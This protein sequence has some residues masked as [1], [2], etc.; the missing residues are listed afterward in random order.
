MG[1]GW[2]L[3]DLHII[4]NE[5]PKSKILSSFLESLGRNRPA[6]HLFLLGDIFDLWVGSS[7]FFADQYSDVVRS[8]IK[9][10]KRGIEVI[11][12]EGNH[13]VHIK[14]FWSQFGVTVTNQD[15]RFSFNGLQLHLSHGD[16]INPKEV[17]YH[18]YIR[19]VRSSQGFIL[20]NL[21]PGKVWWKIGQYA[22]RKSRR[23]SSKSRPG[24]KE[25]LEKDFIEF[26]KIQHQNAPFDLLIAGHIHCPIDLEFNGGVRPFRAINLGSW[27]DEPR[28]LCLNEKGT[29]WDML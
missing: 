16:F 11:Y 3:S 4:S 2:F 17:N 25:Q 12:L 7:S 24:L 19:W 1:V 29:Y 13:D 14:S 23:H 22:S 21:L 26:S 9:L 18:Q 10:P 28:A 6:T 20:A 5:D 8:L 15:L 27:Y